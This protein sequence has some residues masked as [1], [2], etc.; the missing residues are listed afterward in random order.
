MT[1]YTE[2]YSVGVDNVKLRLQGRILS[3]LHFFPFFWKVLYFP[4]LD[5]F[6]ID[7]KICL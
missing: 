7:I 6:G 5:M 1:P 2:L 4:I 3:Q